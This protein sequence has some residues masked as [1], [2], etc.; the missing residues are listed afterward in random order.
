MLGNGSPWQN[1][2]IRY[3]LRSLEKFGIGIG[4]LFIAGENLPEFIWKNRVIHL[5][6]KDNPKAIGWKNVYQKVRRAIRDTDIGVKT[7]GQF[8]LMMDDVF[9]TRK[10][11]LAAFP[12]MIRKDEPMQFSYVN[13]GDW[14]KSRA[15]TANVLRNEFGIKGTLRDFE[16]HAPLRID[17]EKYAKINLDQFD[18]EPLFV[19]HRSIYGNIYNI[20]AVPASDRKITE[21]TMKH[22]SSI[23]LFVGNEAYFSI[24]DK[25][26]ELGMKEYLA[27]NY[28]GKS[29]W[30]KTPITQPKCVAVAVAK[31]EENYIEEWIE[32]NLK[33][34]FDKIYVYLNNW[35]WH[36]PQKYYGMVETK[37]W[38][39]RFDPAVGGH[40]LQ[41]EV[42]NNFIETQFKNW[43]FAAFIDI[44]EF[45]CLKKD[46]NI[47]EFCRRYKDT[48]AIAL[49]WRCFGD[50]GIKKFDGQYSVIKRFNQCERSLSSCIKTIVNLYKTK[51][52][53]RFVSAHTGKTI[54][55][56]LPRTL[57]GNTVSDNLCEE[58]DMVKDLHEAYI[59]HFRVKTPEELEKKIRRN[60][61]GLFQVATQLSRENAALYN[62]NECIDDSLKR[63][64]YGKD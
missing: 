37:Y 48:D 28:P 42:Y 7:D 58:S 25:T 38:N 63:M 57:S 29:R 55:G 32:Y 56:V 2:E 15:N 16:V 52:R 64:M 51:F 39:R 62:R 34:G 46:A 8:L 19:Q 13:Q 4:R 54:T 11:E 18:S 22:A 5:P 45:I 49:H 47:A 10:T 26:L 53:F 61:T 12:V 24:S 6:Y 35:N 1:N 27:E 14:W 50:S 33:L 41:A 36:V 9:L 60:H 31:N 17:R 20:D 44:D 40:M 21:A 23:P 59:C 3:S 43:D 30:E